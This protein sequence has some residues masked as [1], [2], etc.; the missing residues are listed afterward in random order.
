MVDIRLIRS[1]W[2][3][4]GDGHT[5]E[6]EVELLVELVVSGSDVEDGSSLDCTLCFSYARLEDN[7]GA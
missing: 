4:D 7:A 5:D 2:M 6:L 1:A 3:C